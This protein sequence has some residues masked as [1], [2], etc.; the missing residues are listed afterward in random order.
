MTSALIR[1][2]SGEFMVAQRALPPP[3]FVRSLEQ[4]AAFYGI[5]LGFVVKFPG[6]VSGASLI[7]C[8]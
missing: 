5:R 6:R 2:A 1:V 8:A 4:T 7:Q 3:L